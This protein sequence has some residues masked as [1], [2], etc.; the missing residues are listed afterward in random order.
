MM[1]SAAM[2]ALW[3]APAVAQD[4]ELLDEIVV[5]AQKR[6]ETQQTVP[7][8]IKAISGETLDKVNATGLED[9]VRLVPS[10][11][12]TNNSRGGGQIQLRGL[13]S[14]VGNVGTVA[15]YRDGVISVTRIQSSGTFAESDPGTY[16]IERVEVLRGPQG[17]LYG[18]G[19]FGGVINFISKKPDATKI[20]ASAAVTGY[21]I[22][23]G[24]S[25][26]VELQGMINVPIVQDKLALRAVAYHY[27]HGGFIDALNII[28][29]FGGDPPNLA[30]KDA[31]TEDITGGR[32]MLGFT[33]TPDFDATLIYKTE[34]FE[35][36][37]DNFTSP[38]LIPIVNGI[39]G[40]HYDPWTTQAVYSDT[41]PFAKQKSNEGILEINWNT[42]IGRLTSVTGYGKVEQSSNS[43]AGEAKA[44]SE[45]IRLASNSTGPLSWIVGAYYRKAERSIDLPGGIPYVE[46]ELEQRAV[47]GQV[48]WQFAE[49]WRLT[50]GLRYEEQQSSLTDIYQGL[51][52]AT[53]EFNSLI[54]KIALDWQPN[55]RTLVYVSAAKG[56]RA[57][58]N[59]VDESLGTDPTFSQAFDPDQ[60][61]NYELGGKFS[62]FDRKLV[63]NADVFYIDWQD[64]QIDRAMVSVINP[65]INF[66][67]TNGEKAHSY[68]IEADV[69]IRPTPK[70]DIVI[71]GAVMNPE[72]DSGTIDTAFGLDIPLKG[73]QL[74][75][76]PRYTFNASIERRFDLP[77][78]LE[79]YA[80]ADF[81]LR[82]NSYGDV[83]NSPLGDPGTF[84]SC[85][86]KIT[87]VRIGVRGEN[88][89]L[90]GFVNNVF[91]EEASTY[92]YSLAQSSFFDVNATLRPRT[93]GL[94]LK[95]RYN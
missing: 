42:G 27:E 48:Y 25:D 5:T 11:A 71:G 29:V 13:G 20:Q 46:N 73:L 57:G 78:N 2:G 85:E 17:T 91:N 55:D 54:P 58:G 74:A 82:G 22:D 76:S 53:G 69:Y 52:T 51:G 40:T 62:L 16:D 34:D 18:E 64:I 83:P 72:F 86:S 15:I 28:P 41:I 6:A 61:W 36:G 65:P 24:S 1:M 81:S 75:S 93:V 94:S 9:I 33:P 63:I 77:M 32:I 79:G 67:V 59:N 14:N 30:R 89:E 37:L 10:L 88:W 4:S 12:M 39:A 45:E 49:G 68:G 31:N 19:S 56:F 47:F 23:R 87:N 35:R 8:S 21:Q 90:Q 70:W 3:V 95:V 50:A 60:I 7:I 26:N 44:F 80:R 66:I 92:T 84:A 43:S 38:Y